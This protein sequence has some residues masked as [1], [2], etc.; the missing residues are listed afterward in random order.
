MTSFAK[1]AKI[2]HD[3]SDFWSCSC[4]RTDLGID[5][6]NFKDKDLKNKWIF[7][8][9][10]T[11][12]LQIQGHML[13][14]VTF[15]ISGRFR[16]IWEILVSISTSFI[17]RITIKLHRKT[18]TWMVEVYIQGHA[19]FSWPSISQSGIVLSKRSQCL[20]PHTWGWGSQQWYNKYCN[21]NSW[22]SNSRSRTILRDFS[23]LRLC[24]CYRR[25][26]GVYFT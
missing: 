18:N 17:P 19:H 15:Y 11:V 26:L 4:Y 16:A 2:L 24:L 20:F 12:D 1:F 25:D 22:P 14:C 13:V 10:L 3:L 8:A 21:I 7:V 6:H 9:F 23:Y 5:L